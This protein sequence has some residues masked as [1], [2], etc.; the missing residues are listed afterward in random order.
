MVAMLQSFQ[1]FQVKQSLVGEIERERERN[2]CVCVCVCMHM[3][4]CVFICN[5]LATKDFMGKLSA[6]G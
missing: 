1:R 2:V 3:C 6:I 5:R 4:V